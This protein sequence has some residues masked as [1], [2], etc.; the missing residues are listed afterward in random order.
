MVNLNSLGAFDYF[1]PFGF[2]KDAFRSA[3]RREFSLDSRYTDK[4]AGA[5]DVLIKFIE[6]DP[7]ITDI[8]WMAYM[9]ATVYHETALPVREKVR[10]LNKK[11]LPLKDRKGH[12]VVRS[13]K[14]MQVMMRP[15]NEAGRGKG[16]LYFAP[17]KVKKLAHGQAQILEQDGDRFIVSPS[18]VVTSR[19]P[20]K[21][22]QGTALG[23]TSTKAYDG[24]DGEELSYFG[25]GY[26]Q[27]TW[28]SA[29]ATAGRGIGK[30]L[31][32]LFNPEM[33]NEPAIAYAVMS[34]GLRTGEC[35]ANGRKFSKYFHGPTTDYLGARA[36]VNGKDKADVIAE[37]ARRFE[38]ALIVSKAARW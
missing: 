36:M 4:S 3:C 15:V 26:V 37:L 21:A 32:L 20:V 23:T 24:D 6:E 12:P 13:V 17:V 28:W 1:H 18:G 5:L 11:G 31:D 30:G 8:R 16:R 14:S 38:R 2:D 33:A 10:V 19:R 22:A 7:E 9:L 27:L 34:Y 29:Y 25:R 35:F